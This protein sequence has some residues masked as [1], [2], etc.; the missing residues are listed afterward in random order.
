[1]AASDAIRAR[2]VQLYR[3]NNITINRLATISGVTQ[4]N[5][6]NIVSGRNDSATVVT[7]KRICGGLEITLPEF[8][9]C[10]EFLN[11]EQEIK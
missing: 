6:N 1:M 7:I 2:I 5:L 4:S 10:P 11:L 8:F 3:Q 9:D